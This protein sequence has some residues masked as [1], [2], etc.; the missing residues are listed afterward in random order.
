MRLPTIEECQNDPFLHQLRETDK[1]QFLSNRWGANQKFEMHRRIIHSFELINKYLP[2][3][4]DK[5]KKQKRS[6]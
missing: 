4:L 6:V 3:N 5:Q 1:K 2:K